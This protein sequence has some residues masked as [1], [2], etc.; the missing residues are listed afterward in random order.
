MKHFR[1][2][3]TLKFFYLLL[4]DTTTKSRFFFWGEYRRWKAFKSKRETVVSENDKCIGGKGIYYLVP[5]VGISGGI[6]VVFQ[7]ANRLQK[8]GVKVKILSLN[9]QNDDKWFPHQSVEIMP[10]KET[11][12]ILKSGEID[13]LIA[14]GYSTAFTVDMARACRKIYFVQ[15]NESLFFPEDKKL[16]EVIREAYG[17]SFEYMTEAKWIQKWLKEEY[18][19]DSFYVPNGIDPAMFHRTDTLDPKGSKPRIL[20]EGAINIPYKGMDDSYE[21]VKRIDAEIWIIS[22]NGKPRAGWKCDRFFENVPIDEMKNIYSSCDILL[23]MSRVE[24]F[25]GPPMEAMTCGC[26]VVTG[27]V[28]GYDEYIVDGEN[29][30][31]V[32]QGDVDGAQKAIE[33]LMSDVSLREKL[34][35]NGYKTVQEWNWD[36]SI[37]LLEKAIAGRI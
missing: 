7:H 25:F 24:G 29:A 12:K 2:K 21:A 16:C 23:K 5:G 15:S 9:E 31:V 14:T 36:R 20:I 4:I 32:E 13:I 18:G 3:P 6:A 30:L 22:N 26:A 28:S 37:D 8:K 27:K 17:I 19:H 11:K 10:F 1:I 34:I 33:R 35:T